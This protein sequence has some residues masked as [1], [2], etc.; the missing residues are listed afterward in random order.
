MTGMLAASDPAQALDRHIA[1]LGGL[2]SLA[3]ALV[4][5][6]TTI[7]A[8]RAVARK[9]REGLTRDDMYGEFALDSGLLVLTMGVIVAATPLFLGALQYLAIGHERGA[10]R[11]TFAVVWLL[12]IALAVWQG[13]I[14]R[15]TWSTTRTVWAIRA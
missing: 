10:L 11:L 6:F 2:V 5:V 1:D 13:A 15:S 8:S 3:L 12:L 7:R 14:L 4:T 9:R